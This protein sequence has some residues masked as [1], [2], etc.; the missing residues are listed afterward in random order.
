L[1]E[2]GPVRCDDVSG[3][4]RSDGCGLA[5]RIE[6]AIDDVNPSV[7]PVWPFAADRSDRPPSSHANVVCQDV[8]DQRFIDLAKVG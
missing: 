6:K 5:E 8:R 4:D 2:Q 1:S 7:Q 3:I